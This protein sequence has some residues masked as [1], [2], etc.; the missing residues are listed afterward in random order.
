[1]DANDTAWD[2]GRLRG[3]GGSEVIFGFQHEDASVEVALLAKTMGRRALCVASGGETAF[4]LLAAGAPEVVAVDVNPAQLQLI[5]SKKEAI[6]L[7]RLDWMDGNAQQLLRSASLPDS[8]AAFWQRRARVL[9]HGLCFSGIVERR[10]RFLGPLLRWFAKRPDG[11]RWRIGWLLLRFAVATSYSRRLRR[12]LPAGWTA[13]LMTRIARS[14]RQP[15]HPPL[16]LAELGLGFGSDGL[17]L[18][19]PDRAASVMENLGRLRLVRTDLFGFLKDRPDERWSLIALSNIADTMDATERDDLLDIAASR[20][21]PGGIVVARSILHPSESIRRPDD[22][23]PLP[24]PPESGPVC[25]A[26]FAGRKMPS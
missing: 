20:L 4:S 6:R 11:L 5:E 12:T 13:R 22:L 25:P 9:R 3:N 15:P 1:M 14:L 16:V 21:E 8:T 23:E 10:T 19:H 24:L 2:R 18:Y 17:P 7:G 26:I